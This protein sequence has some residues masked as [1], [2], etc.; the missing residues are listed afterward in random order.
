M[1]PDNAFE[2]YPEDERFQTRADDERIG[3]L[4]SK[5]AALVARL[6]AKFEAME[7]SNGNVEATA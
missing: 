6:K 5:H 4:A 7:H 1:L 3:E 2:V